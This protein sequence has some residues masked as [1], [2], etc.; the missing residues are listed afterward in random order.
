MMESMASR[1]DPGAGQ[2]LLRWYRRRSLDLSSLWL[3]RAG[4]GVALLLGLVFAALALTSS[5]GW[6]FPCFLC[7]AVAVACL[8]RS[9]PE[10][11]PLTAHPVPGR[12]PVSR[13]ATAEPPR[14]RE[15][16]RAPER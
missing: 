11:S 7:L 10:E 12:R 9:E 4:A 1:R 5:I 16:R 2:A 15:P 14:H 13:R 3:W 8:V 6:A